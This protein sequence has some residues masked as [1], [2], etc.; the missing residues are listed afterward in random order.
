MPVVIG[1]RTLKQ[2]PQVRPQSILVV[3][4]SYHEPSD[5]LR[6]KCTRRKDRVSNMLRWTAYTAD[7]A[8]K[9][10]FVTLLRLFLCL[11]VLCFYCQMWACCTCARVFYQT[12]SCDLLCISFNKVHSTCLLYAVTFV[13]VLSE[14]QHRPPVL[15]VFD[16]CLVASWLCSCNV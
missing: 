15:F 10:F 11:H 12:F 8:I 16:V 14:C 5:R 2:S 13:Y 4:V 7:V 3:W 1:C 9:I 6:R